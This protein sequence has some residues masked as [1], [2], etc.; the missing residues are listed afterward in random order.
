ML[1]S[2]MHQGIPLVFFCS[3]QLKYVTLSGRVPSHL[4]NGEIQADYGR[5]C[6]HMA[7]GRLKK[8][9]TRSLHAH[10]AKFCRV[11]PWRPLYLAT[12]GC[13]ICYCYGSTNC[14]STCCAASEK[15]GNDENYLSTYVRGSAKVQTSSIWFSVHCRQK[16]FG[17]ILRVE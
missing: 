12:Y 11:W 15:L 1:S 10:G 17:W 7:G 9:I 2:S 5:V 8:I 16:Q 6:W 4:F 13:P 3:Y 14:N